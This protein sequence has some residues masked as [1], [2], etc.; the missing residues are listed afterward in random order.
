MI[1]MTIGEI[2]DRYTICKLKS[3]RTDID[4]REELSLLKCEIDQYKDINT[5]IEKL[6]TTNGSIWLLESDIRKGKEDLLGLE[7]VGRRAIQ[8]RNLNAIRVQT[9]NDI[10]LKYKEGF[11]EIKADHASQTTLQN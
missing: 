6:Y 1:K 11:I 4:C 9:K 5:Y 2:A 8:I 7:E 10:N 3:E